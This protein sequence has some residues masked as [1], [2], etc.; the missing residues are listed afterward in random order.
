M[1]DPI[2]ELEYGLALANEH[3]RRAETYCQLGDWAGRVYY[4]THN[5][6]L[7]TSPRP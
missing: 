5:Y 7:R 1:I 2:R 4:S 3:L 6:P